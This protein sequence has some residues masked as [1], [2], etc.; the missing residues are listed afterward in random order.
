MRTRCRSDTS[1]S[2]WPEVSGGHHTIKGRG[3]RLERLHGLELADIGFVGVDDGLLRLGVGVGLVRQLLSH[4]LLL[5]QDVIAVGGQRCDLM[6]G[7]DACQRRLGLAELLIEIGRIDGGQHLACLDRRS[8]VVVP[9]L[10]VTV[11]AREDRRPVERLDIAGQRQ[12]LMRAAGDQSGER[13]R[14]DGMGVGP[15]HHLLL[16][17]RAADEAVAEHDAGDQD[18]GCRGGQKAF[19]AWRFDVFRG[20]FHLPPLNAIVSLRRLAHLPRWTSGRAPG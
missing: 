13:N 4:D 20:H 5:Q 12:R 19:P 6:I 10:H 11:D 15:V 1:N 9:A 18:G 14:G 2:G 16:A 17:L 8:D 3:Q 7:P